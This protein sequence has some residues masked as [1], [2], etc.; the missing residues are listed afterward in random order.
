MRGRRQDRHRIDRSAGTRRKHTRI[1]HAHHHQAA[2]SEQK[3]GLNPMKET[4]WIIDAY[5]GDLT[6]EG[7]QQAALKDL[8]ADL[9]P[10]GKPVNCARPIKIEPLRLPPAY[11]ANDE[12][13]I[14]VFR[15]YH[16]S[17]VEGPGRRSVVQT[18]GCLLRC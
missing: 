12:S 8:A 3:E 17:V 9:L 11:S 16:N 14:R 18:A 15:I 2:D 13:S 10:S 5:S 1:F 6:V 4:T 7:L